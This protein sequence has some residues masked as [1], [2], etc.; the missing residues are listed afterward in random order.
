MIS[1]PSPKP[2]CFTGISI[3]KNH[4]SATTTS[5]IFLFTALAAGA[6]AFTSGCTKSGAQSAPPPPPL[7]T[8]AAVEQREL[9]E[10][11]EFTGR[12]ESTEFVEIRPRISGYLQEVR[13]QSGQ[14]VKK[15][16]V[17]FVIDPRWQKA[18]Y[19]H[20]AADLEAVKVRVQTAEREAK[21]TADLLVSR[22][23]SKEEAEARE[24]KFLEAKAAMLSAEAARQTVSLDLEFTE[25]RAPIDGRVSRALVTPGNYVSGVAG[26]GTVL[27]TLVSV[28]PIYVYAHVDENTLL[29]FNT[30]VH[31]RKLVRNA[32]GQVPVELQLADES[33]FPRR[34][35][36]ESFDNRLDPG[37]GSMLLRSVFSNPEGR[38]LPG[39]FARIRI[40]GGARV[41]ALLIDEAAIGTDHAQ[42]FVL[43]LTSTN[44]TAYR[45]VKLGASVDGKRVVREGL[46]AGDKVV[47]NLVAARVRPGMAVTPQENPAP[48]D[49]AKFAQK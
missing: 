4:M 2:S 18:A 1:N 32:D 35:A 8:V 7:V 17:L 47:L 34:G 44:T 24:S 10:W 30:L 15:N 25:V 20:A 45:P 33:G 22:A 26:A 49:A 36:I 3:P 38:I 31:D 41:P 11:D 29:K 12:T 48:S 9:I 42:K 43:A 28:D 14:L 19:D 46:Q 13:F 16:D 27:T 23:I 6:A 40:P 37:M 21:R 5:R 39:L